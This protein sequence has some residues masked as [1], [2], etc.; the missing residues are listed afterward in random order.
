[1]NNQKIFVLAP[2]NVVT[3][4]AELLHQLVDVVNRNGGDAYIV[5][6]SPGVMIPADYKKYSI[7]VADKIEDIESNI[8]VLNEGV[9]N[10]VTDV[11]KAKIVL[12]WLSVDN[13]YH[14]NRKK[15]CLSD[16]WMFNKGMFWKEL[17][18]RI[19]RFRMRYE[20]SIEGLK[21]NSQVVVNGYQSEYAHSFLK[22][23]GFNSLRSLGDYID[24]EYLKDFDVVIKENAVAYNPKKGYEFTRK[25]IASAPD[26]DWRPISGLDRAGVIELLKRCKVY[27][28]FGNHPGKD[29]LPREAALCGCVIITGRR[30]SAAFSEDVPI[31][32]SYK[33]NQYRVN[34]KDVVKKIKTAMADYESA[35][36]DFSDYK[37]IISNEKKVF[38]S[39]IKDVFL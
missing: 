11:K 28:D 34:V 7:K 3:G 37:S 33:M 19:K 18:N 23:N 12:W 9:F 38:E 20:V 6:S 10:V 24:S 22:K 36:K 15:L 35:I 31:L 30:G 16:I 26:L 39:E 13:F 1:M 4:G 8:I 14:C 29:R 17:W 2:A 5:Y 25:L 21:R 27:I 32:D